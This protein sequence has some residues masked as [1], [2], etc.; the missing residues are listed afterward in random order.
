MKAAIRRT[1][2]PIDNLKIESVEKPTAK[3]NEVLIRVYATT[4]N[5]TD[6]A[7]LT[8]KPFVMRFFTGLLK[9]K[10]PI[11]GTDFAGI[12][13]AVGKKVKSFKVNDKVFGF[14]DQGLS[15]QAEYMVFPEDG[16]MTKIP[17][18]ISYEQAAAS[19]EGAHY[20]YNFINKVNLKAEHKILI[21]GATGG[22]GSALLQFLKYYNIYVTAVCDTKNLELIKSLGADRI[23][24]YTKEDFTNDDEKYDFVFDAVGKSTFA[25]CKPL[26]KK[27]GVY[28]SSELGPMVQNPFL[29]LTTKVIGDKKVIFPIPSDI[30]RSILFIKDLLE[31][32]KFKPVIDRKYPLE[33]IGEAY[34]YVASGQKTGNVIISFENHVGSL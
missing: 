33:N 12:V 27:G 5:R 19:L 13:E 11:P 25:K 6:Y 34:S 2:G 8:G 32:E 15:S 24:D 22:I 14:N 7:V 21:N 3:D 20:A 1:Y 29:A 16:A 30:K 9:P 28:I 26:L 23:Y 18:N 31:K 4:V 10:L 17:D